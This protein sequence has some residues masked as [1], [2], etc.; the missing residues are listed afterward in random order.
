MP[1]PTLKPAS[2]SLKAHRLDYAPPLTFWERMR[3]RFP[4]PEQVTTFLKN[5]IWV[6]PLTLLIWVYAERE[7]SVTDEKPRPVAIDV[8]T[9]DHNRIV[10]LRSPADKN[11]LVELSGP[12]A[13]LE[14]V[15][16][17][18]QPKPDGPAAIEIDIDPR[19]KPGGQEL[20]TVGQINNLPVFRDNGITVKN[21]QPPYLRVDIDVYETRRVPVK[22]PPEL[23]SVLTE[24]AHFTPDSVEIRAPSQQ[25]KRAEAE[26]PLFAYADLPKADQLKNKAGE[27]N[28][29]SV[30]VYWP[31]HRENVYLSPLI[32]A[33]KLNVRRRDAEYTIPSVTIVKVTPKDFENRFYVDYVPQISNVTV[34]GPSE[35][36]EA[37]RKN[38][39]P[40]RAR[41]EITSQDQ[42][43]VEI[44][45]PLQFELPPGVQLTQESLDRNA[46]GYPFTIKPNGQ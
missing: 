20:L 29:D 35:Q 28:L 11:I 22:A 15:H 5:L 1:E 27:V 38:E 18:L 16:Q 26:G 40:Y 13:K 41:L 14:H 12:R 23:A 24:Q 39:F 30:P 21:A 43:G 4:A 34:S 37:L 25:F 36:I 45:K 2:T 32:V 10:V 33:A 31:Q 42:V 44:R 9:N 17:L 7:Q 8:K 46:L 3:R 19:L 6:A